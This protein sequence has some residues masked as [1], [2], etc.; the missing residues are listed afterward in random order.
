MTIR[1][2]T[3]GVYIEEVTPP[4]AIVGVDTGTTAFVG[5]AARGP[6]DT[7]TLITSFPDFERVF[8]GLWLKSDLGHSIRDFFEQGGRRVVVVRAHLH[9]P[10]DV[11][12]LTFGR[13]GSR[14][15]LEASSPGAWSSKLEAT[16]DPLPRN[17]FDLKVTDQGTGV[18]ETFNGCSLAAGSPRR[19]DRV[20]EGSAL[21]RA[22]S[23]LPSALPP[24]LPITVTASGGNDGRFGIPAYVGAGMRESSRGIYALDRSDLVNLI[25]LPPFSTV[26]S[27]PRK[28]LTAAIAYAGERRAMVVLD[29]PSTWRTVNDA[30]ARRQ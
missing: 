11:A 1:Y 17:R 2:R 4:Q 27:V 21:I 23:P 13:G 9:T 29:P 7:P 18:V 6:I 28:V 22:R 5:R 25:V 14:F 19:V 26:A 12:T 15:V 20:L 3:P 10:D 30:A 16:I 24:R 8:G